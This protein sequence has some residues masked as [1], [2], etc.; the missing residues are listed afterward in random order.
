MTIGYS[1]LLRTSIPYLKQMTRKCS[2]LSLDVQR[3][4]FFSN[5]MHT[6][7]H[8][9]RQR[10]RV[11][12]APT[13]HQRYANNNDIL[14]SIATS[15]HFNLKSQKD[16]EPTRTHTHP[17]FF[18]FF[19]PVYL[20]CHLF[21][22][23]RE[24]KD[25]VHVLQQYTWHDSFMFNFLFPIHVLC[26]IEWGEEQTA[27]LQISMVPHTAQQGTSIVTL[28]GWW[29]VGELTFGEKWESKEA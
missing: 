10:E 29:M 4:I 25:V 6:S 13:L 12:I 17:H 15:C 27:P 14:M 16:K 11:T 26:D 24:K 21:L 28:Q 3:W 7:M 19:N 23:R 2:Y 5:H 1:K 20:S 9:N 22:S 8:K 18:F